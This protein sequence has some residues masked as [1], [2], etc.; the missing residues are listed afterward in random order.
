MPENLAQA[1]P[2]DQPNPIP[3]KVS[4]ALEHGGA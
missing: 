3:L 2:P 1:L 4:D